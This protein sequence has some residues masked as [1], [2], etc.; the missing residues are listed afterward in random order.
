MFWCFISFQIY[1]AYMLGVSCLFVIFL[2]LFKLI[3]NRYEQKQSKQELDLE[4]A[5]SN[6]HNEAKTNTSYEG[7]IVIISRRTP[8]GDRDVS[9]GPQPELYTQHQSPPTCN[10]SLYMRIG[11]AGKLLFSLTFKT[12]N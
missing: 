2:E 6:R 1:L 10:T 7:N 8:P 5:N 3:T 12:K 4:V 11:T 9:P